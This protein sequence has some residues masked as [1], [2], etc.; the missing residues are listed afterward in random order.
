MSTTPAPFDP[1]LPITSEDKQIAMLVHMSSL[2]G[3]VMGPTHV[4]VPLIVWLV[5]K[6]SSPFVAYHSMQALVFQLVSSAIAWSIMIVVLLFTFGLCFPI[7]LVGFVPVIFGVLEGIKANEGKWSGYPGIR[8]IGL[9]EGV[10]LD[11]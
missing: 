9:P 1:M 2:L 5:K 11:G 7:L 4:I 3:M 8:E 6:D 10:E